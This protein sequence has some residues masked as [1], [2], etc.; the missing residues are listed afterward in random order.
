MSLISIRISSILL[1]YSLIL[2]GCSG[3]GQAIDN[4]Q[5]TD[6]IR[7]KGPS[8]ET[9]TRLYYSD[10]TLW[11]YDIYVNG[12]KFIHQPRIPGLSGKRGFTNKTDAQRVANLVEGKI[13][14]HINPPCIT[15]DELDSLGVKER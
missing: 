3:G 12:R 10:S 6:T 11:G 7:S 5:V 4:K 15:T 14:N 9:E 13:K 8:L 1:L 2:A